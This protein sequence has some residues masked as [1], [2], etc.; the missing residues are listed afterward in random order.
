[1]SDYLL[2][3]LIW[4]PIAGGVVLLAMGDDNNPASSRAQAMRWTV[5]AIAAYLGAIGNEKLRAQIASELPDRLALATRHTE[6]D[7][8]PVPRF[9]AYWQT[10]SVVPTGRR[11][12]CSGSS[13]PSFRTRSRLRIWKW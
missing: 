3:I 11:T 10:F 6:R 2:S 4:L 13:G 8:G 9:Q 5:M 1:M 7:A 12:I